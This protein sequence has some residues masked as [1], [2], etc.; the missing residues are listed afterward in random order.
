MKDK[1]IMIGIGSRPESDPMGAEV[2]G[3]KKLT[4]YVRR[5]GTKR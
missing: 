5:N 3:L 2:E 1:T 4:G